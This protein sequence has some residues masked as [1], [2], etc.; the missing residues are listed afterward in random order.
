M[1]GLVRYLCND[2][3]DAEWTGQWTTAKHHKHLSPLLREFVA[4]LSTDLAESFNLEGVGFGPVR[5]IKK[6]DSFK[7]APIVYTDTV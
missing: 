6:K 1:F 5:I 2:G 4:L 7:C 3:E